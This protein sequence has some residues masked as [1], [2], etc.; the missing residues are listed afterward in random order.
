MK[1]LKARVR[2]ITDDA[3]G[4]RVTIETT[5]QDVLQNTSPYGLDKD[6]LLL[7]LCGGIRD[8]A[9]T[10]NIRPAESDPTALALAEAQAIQE[11]YGVDL[12][13]VL[14]ETTEKAE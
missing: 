6:R 8:C 14:P 5:I 13:A 11:K 7:A 3:G 2:A 9:V 12:K 10:L 4:I 1:A